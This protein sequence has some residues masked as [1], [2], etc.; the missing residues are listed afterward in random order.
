MS[1]KGPEASRYA[2]AQPRA[3]ELDEMCKMG[4]LKKNK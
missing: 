2:W 3:V 4:G 1:D